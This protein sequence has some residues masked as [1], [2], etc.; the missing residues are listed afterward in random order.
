MTDSSPFADR[1]R[2]SDLAFGVVGLGYV[3]LPLAVEGARP[4]VY[5]LGLD[6]KTGVVEGINAGR[7]HIQDLSDSNVGEVVTGGRLEDTHE[8]RA[9]DVAEAVGYRL[10]DR[11]AA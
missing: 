3:G 1:F 11:P 7:S 8:I 2:A 4:G 6:V 9:L 10:L 5:V